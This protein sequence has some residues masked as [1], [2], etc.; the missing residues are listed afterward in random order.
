MIRVRRGFRAA[1]IYE[2]ELTHSNSPERDT[3]LLRLRKSDIVEKKSQ[4]KPQI[5]DIILVCQKHG[6]RLIIIYFSQL[7]CLHTYLTKYDLFCCLLV[8]F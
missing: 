4:K 8:A 6:T 3:P 7:F 2:R 1:Y 5:F